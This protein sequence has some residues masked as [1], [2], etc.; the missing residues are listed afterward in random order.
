MKDLSEINTKLFTYESIKLRAAKSEPFLLAGLHKRYKDV[1]K[2]IDI[3]YSI[4]SFE[5]QLDTLKKQ[6]TFLS[7]GHYA[8]SPAKGT[9]A[10][11]RWWNIKNSIDYITKFLTAVKQ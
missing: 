10:Y 9:H 2:A 6:L 11:T 4:H 5:C 1:Q 7:V 8:N 3:G